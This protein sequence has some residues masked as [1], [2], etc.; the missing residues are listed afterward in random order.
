MET[1]TTVKKEKTKLRIIY[2]P[3]ADEFRFG[4]WGTF[5]DRAPGDPE[6]EKLRKNYASLRQR[7]QDLPQEVGVVTY[8]SAIK[9]L[10]QGWREEPEGL[11]S[12]MPL[13]ILNRVLA[14]RKEEGDPE[15]A[16][17]NEYIYIELSC[18]SLPTPL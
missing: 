4:D 12:Y 7:F 1:K 15:N 10:A 16:L 18:R 14:L 11:E 13:G 9:R 17:N 5:F 6:T 3:E 2:T 8:R